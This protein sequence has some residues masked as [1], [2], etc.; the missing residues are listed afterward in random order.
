M[1]QRRSRVRPLAKWAALAACVLTAALWLPTGSWCIWRINQARDGWAHV[2]T[3]S[4]GTLGIKSVRDRSIS[5]G[6]GRVMWGWSSSGSMPRLW[7]PLRVGLSPA[8]AFE[9]WVPLWLPFAVVAMPTIWLWWHDRR[10]RPGHCPCGYSLA[11]LKRGA[12]CPECGR[13]QA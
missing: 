1:G 6:S 12:P 9:L 11:G 4:Q 8:G 2:V 7:W 3:V 10:M 13:G 5:A